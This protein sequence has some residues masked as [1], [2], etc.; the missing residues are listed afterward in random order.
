MNGDDPRNDVL[1]NLPYIPDYLEWQE[2][3]KAMADT[4]ANNI[5]Q[6]EGNPVQAPVQGQVN[7][8]QVKQAAQSSDGEVV[9]GAGNYT[10]GGNFP[11]GTFDLQVL[12]GEGAF[13][14]YDDKG[15]SAYNWMGGD[16]GV[17]SWNGSS[18]D[19]NRSF[20]LEGSLHVR[21][22]RAQMIQI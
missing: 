17:M 21:V 22:T 4:S 12:S 2:S 8:A 5:P 1:L 13:W 18:S 11:T 14:I 10:F 6:P 15:E 3:E 19:G 7:E 16:H 9:I 20:T